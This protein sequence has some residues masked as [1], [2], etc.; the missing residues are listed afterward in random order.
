MAHQGITLHLVGS[1]KP[2]HSTLFQSMFRW[3]GR[4][5]H[6]DATNQTHTPSESVV[7]C[8]DLELLLEECD[9]QIVGELT[10]STSIFDLAVIKRYF[11]YLTTLLKSMAEDPTRPVSTIDILSPEER[12]PISQTWDEASKVH[13]E[14]QC[15]HRL[16]EF[17][18]DKIPNA[19]AVVQDDQVLS[20]GDLNSRSNCL[21]HYLIELGVG[22]ETRVAICA[23]RSVGMIVGTL[24]IMKTGAT[25]VPLNPD[26]SSECLHDI[27]QDASPTIVL[28]DTIGKTVLG[29]ASFV[30]VDPN[31]LLETSIS[32]PYV[33]ELAPCHLVYILYTPGSASQP[34]GMMVEHRGVANLAHTHTNLYDIQPSSRILQFAPCGSDT[35]VWE[36]LLPLING[37]SIYIPQAVVCQ[38]LKKLWGYMAK[39]SITLAALPPSFFQGLSTRM[40]KAGDL[41]RYLPDGNIVY[42]RR[43]DDQIIDREVIEAPFDEPRRKSHDNH[44][45]FF[46]DMLGDI[47]EPAI[48]FGLSNT[49]VNSDDIAESHHVLPADLN[50][51]L[52]LHAKQMKVNVA[53]LCHVAWAQVVARTSGQDRVVFGTVLPGEEDHT[54]INILPFRCDTDVQ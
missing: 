51:R 19:T 54:L 5:Q 25:V 15:I 53:S 22:L 37:A 8:N 50:D 43:E 44:E 52:Q 34:K 38:D 13:S 24:A 28:A 23:E 6:L 49:H 10:F 17:Q 2:S 33:S 1:S 46:K 39:H 9:D 12:T 14:H 20:Y 41:A 7:V 31:K 30:I 40:F 21:A 42:L 11:Q 47:E 45:K 18:A 29:Q 27:L 48:P 4:G 32:N 3:R 16:F 26:D 35:C 36:V